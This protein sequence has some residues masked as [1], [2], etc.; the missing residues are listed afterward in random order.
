MFDVYEEWKKFLRYATDKLCKELFYF[1]EVK[2]FEYFFK[3]FFNYEI[4][5]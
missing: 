2:E 1:A 4:F 5:D 3:D